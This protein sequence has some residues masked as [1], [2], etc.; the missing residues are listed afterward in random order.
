MGRQACSA[1]IMAA[2]GGLRSE[3]GHGQVGG[4]CQQC[5]WQVRSIRQQNVPCH[6]PAGW[7]VNGIAAHGAFIPC[8]LLHNA[9]GGPAEIYRDDSLV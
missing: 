8:N 4:Q 7:G 5:C 6:Q 2:L 3:G 1:F 9:S